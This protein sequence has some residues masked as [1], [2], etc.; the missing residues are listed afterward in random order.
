MA[1]APATGSM[2]T[3]ILILRNMDIGTAGGIIGLQ[4]MGAADGAGYF[5]SRA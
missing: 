5:L 4:F 3:G 2:G 1:A